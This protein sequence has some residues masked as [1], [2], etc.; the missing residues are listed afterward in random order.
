MEM[1]KLS[2]VF[3]ALF[4][5]ASFISCDKKDTGDDFFPMKSTQDS[6][7][8]SVINQASAPVSDNGIIPYI[9]PGENNGGNRTCGEVETAFGL[10]AGYFVCGEKLDYGEDGFN[11]EFA[12]G[13]NV[14]VDGTWVSFEME[15]CILIGD[16]FYQVGAV[17]VKG[18]SDANIYYYKDGT[19]ND[20]G[21][22]SPVNASGAPS[23]LSNLSFCFVECKDSKPVVIAVKSQIAQIVDDEELWNFS[24][25]SG[26]YYPFSTS[27]C[28]CSMLGV[29][30]LNIGDVYEFKTL[31]REPGIQVGT[32]SVSRGPNK[33][34]ED[35]LIVEVDGY[36]DI[37]LLNTYLYIGTL[38]GLKSSLG[39]DNCP[40]YESWK[41]QI[42]ERSNTHTFYISFDEL[43]GDI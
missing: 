37:R 15:S 18:S 4:L 36:D 1:K 16:K 24:V 22:A 9:I 12:E 19:L 34:E 33:E 25:S 14:T 5:V 8:G 27:D 28:W 6:G 26:G 32:I 38:D 43:Q 13:L 42:H 29:H 11:G 21:L 23:G 40:D 30:E 35:C 2:I 31:F 10:S 20:S 17:I 3:G 7:K 41:W 39:T